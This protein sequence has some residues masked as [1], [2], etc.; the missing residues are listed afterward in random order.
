[1]RYNPIPKKGDKSVNF[2]AWE[3]LNRQARK[4]LNISFDPTTFQTI[5]D[6]SGIYIYANPSAAETTTHDHRWTISNANSTTVTVDTGVINVMG[7]ENPWATDDVTGLAAGDNTIYGKCPRDGLGAITMHSNNGS[8]P[9]SSEIGNDNFGFAVGNIN[10]TSGVI[11]QYIHS[12][13]LAEFPKEHA[14]LYKVQTLREY[15]E[16][17]NLVAVGAETNPLPAGH[18]YE[19]AIDWTRAHG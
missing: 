10:T 11:T 19:W 15:D 2:S 14:S 7:K 18:Y 4:L 13:F 8:M 1:M 12:D 9:T 5:E 17:G 3:N 16:D 6:P